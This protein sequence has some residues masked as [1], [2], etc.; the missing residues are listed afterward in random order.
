M[1]YYTCNGSPNIATVIKD[2]RTRRG[3]SQEKLAN[4][5]GFSRATISRWENGGRIPNLK[6]LSK[7]LGALGADIQIVEDGQCSIM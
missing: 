6:T 2:L 4:L 5:T 1:I 3:Y 7:L